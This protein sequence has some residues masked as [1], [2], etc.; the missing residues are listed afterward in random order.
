MR[1]DAL[2]GADFAIRLRVESGAHVAPS[3]RPARRERAPLIAG[4]ESRYTLPVPA[5]NDGQPH[6]R[7]TGRG[8]FDARAC[9]TCSAWATEQTAGH[10]HWP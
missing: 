1:T 7:Q 10:V 5:R 8:G 9:P 3:T 2:T 6:A 4:Q